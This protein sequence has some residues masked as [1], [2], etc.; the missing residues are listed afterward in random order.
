MASH[1][2]YST[3]HWR[4]L[5]ATAL[6]RDRGLCAIPGCIMPATVVDHIITRPRQSEPSP[7]DRLDNLRSLCASHD[8][9]MKEHV[10]G[11]RGPARLK[12][13]DADGWP[14]GLP[15]S[16]HTSSQ[17]FQISQDEWE[18]MQA[19]DVKPHATTLR[20]T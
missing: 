20:G 13:C 11:A 16:I 15:N 19:A 7:L 14:R 18:R 1:G 8:A 10:G 6:R 5:R 12:G 3:R 9:Q 17:S 4:E 2:Y